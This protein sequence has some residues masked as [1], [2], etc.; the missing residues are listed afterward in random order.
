MPHEEPDREP[1]EGRDG[2][3]SGAPP[4]NGGRADQHRPLAGSVWEW[5]TAAVSLVIVLGAI[6]FLLVDAAGAP[7][8]PP[9]IELVI[10]SIVTSGDGY[11]VE[12]RAVNSGQTTAAGLHIAAALREGDRT[13]ETSEVEIDYVPREGSRSAGLFFGHDPRGYDL[14]MRPTGYR[15]P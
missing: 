1:P 8:T 2:R 3:L 14:E 13:L 5:I 10:D 11:L 7:P 4:E 12:F 15:R 9:H 6:A